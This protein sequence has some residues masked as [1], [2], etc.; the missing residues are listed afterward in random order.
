MYILLDLGLDDG[1][2]EIL[3]KMSSNWTVGSGHSA[4][5]QHSTIAQNQEL[6]VI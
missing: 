5:V 6:V 1:T 2:A 4:Q 3:S